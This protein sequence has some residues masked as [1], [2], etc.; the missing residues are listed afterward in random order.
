M[1]ISQQSGKAFKNSCL[2]ALL[3][4]DGRL[5]YLVCKKFLV[6]QGLSRASLSDRLQKQTLMSII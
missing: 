6:S 2:G 3:H 5:F 1:F 4:F